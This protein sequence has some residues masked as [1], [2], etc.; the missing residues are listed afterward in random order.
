MKRSA[1]QYA[2]VLVALLVMSWVQWTAEEPVDLEG[3]VVMLQG[4]PEDVSAVRWISTETESTISRKKD[5]RGEYFWVD[6]TRWSEKRLPAARAEGEEEAEPAI[7]EPEPEREAKKSAFKSAQKAFDMVSSLSPMTARRSLDVTD[8]EKLKE[9]GLTEPSGT[10]EIDRAGRT[11]KLEVGGEAYGT[12]DYYV[13]H[14]ESGKVFLVE[15]DLLQPLK[16][17]RTRLPDRTLVGTER[18]DVV[19]ATLVKGTATLALVQIHAD[20]PE[21]AGW[22]PSDQPEVEAEQ[23][24]TWME[25]ML[26]LKGTR[27]AN[28]S[29]LPENLQPR[30][31]VAMTDRTSLVTTV[32]VLQ[33][34]DDGDWYARSEHTRGLIKLIRSAARGLSD[35]VDG[36]VGSE[37]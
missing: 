32:E 16:Y 21:K 15:R 2:L 5:E 10:I 17:A 1:Q 9:I 33:V 22:S 12:R 18:M 20:D 30:F 7:P 23:A 4:E 29:E 14:V 27:Y 3:K 13:R 34:G 28:P 19:A 35:D 6:Y 25:R 24:T 26:N 31:S 37:D 11:Q 8:E 36:I